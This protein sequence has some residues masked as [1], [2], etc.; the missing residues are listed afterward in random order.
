LRE[1]SMICNILA[2]EFTKGSAW[3]SPILDINRIVDGRRTNV[4][5]FRVASKKEA[6]AIAKSYNAQPWNF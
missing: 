4:T 3:R 6:R 2:A 5:T 1:A